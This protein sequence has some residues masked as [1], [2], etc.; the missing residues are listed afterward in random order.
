[1]TRGRLFQRLL[2][3][4]AVFQGIRIASI[5][6]DLG[7]SRSWASREANSPGTRVILRHL[8]EKRAEMIAI[9]IEHAFDVIEDGLG[10]TTLI[11]TA[12]GH[13]EVPDHRIRLK[14]VALFTRLVST[15][16]FVASGRD[17]ERTCRTAALPPIAPPRTASTSAAD[18]EV[19][20]EAVRVL[21]R[22][23]AKVE[24]GG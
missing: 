22:M 18:H 5:A 11:T 21:I 12:N 6:R 10:A 8:V 1:M 15:P 3:A 7:V 13:I 20:F 23:V 4:E 2:I 14:A 17:N 24:R 19:R 9:L 16:L